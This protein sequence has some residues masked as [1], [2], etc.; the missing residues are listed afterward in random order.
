MKARIGIIGGGTF[1]SILA[2]F[3]RHQGHAVDVWD[4]GELYAGHHS[5]GYFFKDTGKGQEAK[6]ML[7]AF[8]VS[9]VARLLMVNGGNGRPVYVNH[10]LPKDVIVK[11]EFRQDPHEHSA[12]FAV[13]CYDVVVRACGVWN[14]GDPVSYTAAALIHPGPCKFQS[15]YRRHVMNH[16]D[17]IQAVRDDYTGY[18]VSGEHVQ[19]ANWTERDRARV[20]NIARGKGFPMDNSVLLEGRL[21]KKAKHLVQEFDG[22]LVI[23]GGGIVQAVDAAIEVLQRVNT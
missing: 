14:P 2:R 23:G 16:A 8:G 6:H 17:I 19:T 3:A 5:A 13:G 12:A 22:E 1:G 10:I 15:V 21:T 18:F 4:R 9:P 7:T 20:R 11:P